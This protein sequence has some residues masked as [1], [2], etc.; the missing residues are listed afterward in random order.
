[1]STARQATTSAVAKELAILH[2]I[3]TELQQ[4]LLE[5]TDPLRAALVSVVAKSHL[6]LLGPPGTGKSLLAEQVAK[7]FCNPNGTGLEYFV[8][9]LTRFT[10]PEEL[11]GPFDI[12]QLQAGVWERVLRNKLAQ[13]EI[14][15]LDEVF[16]ASSAVL[17]TLLT[18]L[19]ER[20]F[21]NGVMRLPI[22]L[23]TLFGASNEM[24]QEQQDLEALWDRFLIRMEV[25]YLSEGSLEKLLL[26][27]TAGGQKPAPTTMSQGNLATLQQAASSLPIPGSVVSAMIKLRVDLE[28]QHGIIASDRRWVQCLD[29]LRAHAL[30]EGRDAVESDDLALLEHCL[31][32]QPSQRQE[33][34]KMV[35]KLANPLNAKANTIKDELIT[36]RDAA[37]HDLQS[38]TGTDDKASM[39]RTTITVQTLGKIRAA[40]KQLAALR[41]QAVEQTL[42]TKR[43]DQAITVADQAKA[44]L[45]EQG[46]F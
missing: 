6:V 10:T 17:N 4:D 41:E 31:W 20:V 34:S 36:L 18:L 11:F 2:Q 5:R 44:T 7:R 3:E 32:S 35:G 14:A 33:I 9:L 25:K 38:T 29:V 24:P 23:V 40:A 12:S 45:M 37:L 16:K 15:F 21:D 8:Y 26:R 30:I 27:Q 46:E 19:N 39:A 28:K 1:M 42:P 22:P 43:I 13:A